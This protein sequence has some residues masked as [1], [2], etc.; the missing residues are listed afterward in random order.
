MYCEI[1][2]ITGVARPSASTANESQVNQMNQARKSLATFHSGQ[3]P[4]SLKC[5]TYLRARAR[6]LCPIQKH[7]TMDTSREA[8]KPGTASQVSDFQ[9]A[10][11]SPFRSGGEATPSY[12]E[13]TRAAACPDSGSSTRPSIPIHLFRSGPEKL[14]IGSDFS[15]TR[16]DLGK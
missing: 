9:S 8:A 5:L 11:T 6:A 10:S 7:N 13:P 1:R 2:E 15:A 16:Q 3:T 14:S 12:M 4:L